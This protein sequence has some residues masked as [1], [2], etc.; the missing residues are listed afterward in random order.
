MYEPHTEP[1][2][3]VED[4]SVH[5]PV[6]GG[7]PFGKKKQVKAVDHI[8]LCIPKGETFG[9]VGESGCGKSTLGKVLLHL[10]ESTAGQIFFDGADITHFNERRLRDYRKRMQMIFQDPQAS[11][12]P[13]KNVSSL[14][15]EPLKNYKLTQSR[16]EYEERVD[17][18]MRTVGLASIYKESYSHELDGGRRQR[19]GVGRALA[20]DPEFIVCDEPVSAVAGQALKMAAPMGRVVMY[21]SQHPDK[22]VEVSPGWLH[23]ANPVITGAVNPSVRSFLHAVQLLNKGLIDPAKLFS[24]EFG[25]DD[26]QKAFEAAIRPDTFR[27]AIRMV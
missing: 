20:V 1:L 9:L 18:I 23:S 27:I 12:D 3:R 11:L 26:A 4:V 7:L 13:R 10:H 17:E 22:P 25:L 14:I 19:I 8:S 24:G 5:F 15:G 16:A 2:V 6:R 21:S